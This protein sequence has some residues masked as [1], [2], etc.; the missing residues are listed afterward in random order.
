MS[1]TFSEAEAATQERAQLLRAVWKEVTDVLPIQAELTWVIATKEAITEYI[2]D[3]LVRTKSTVSVIVPTFEDLP[4]EAIMQT[5]ST[6]RVIVATKILATQREQVQQMLAKGNIQIRQRP[7]GDIFSC[8][9]DGEEILIAP[10]AEGIKPSETVAIVSQQVGFAKQFHE[11]IG[12]MWMSR[13]Q[14]IE[15]I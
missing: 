12:P 11:L 8:A 5:P 1:Q 15:R 6:R 14:K 2:K 10:Y 4:F 7:E 13:A 9:R 3:M